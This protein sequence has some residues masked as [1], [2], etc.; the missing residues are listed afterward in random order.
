M[1]ICR[2]GRGTE[3]SLWPAGEVLR[4]GSCCGSSLRTAE[5]THQFH[6][7]MHS[8]RHWWL[9]G[10]VAPNSCPPGPVK[11]VSLGKR[12]FAGVTKLILQTPQVVPKCKMTILKQT[13]RVRPGEEGRLHCAAASLEPALCSRQPGAH[14]LG[15]R[16]AF[17]R[18]GA[19][20]VRPLTPHR[21]PPLWETTCLLL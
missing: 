12:A 11:G 9:G 10:T 17:W 19:L 13:E 15:R 5:M 4:K 8:R 14:G 21:R 20:Q 16:R 18:H 2:P 3:G 7:W 1:P 6:T